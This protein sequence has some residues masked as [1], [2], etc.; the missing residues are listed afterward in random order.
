EAQALKDQIEKRLGA[1]ASKLAQTLNAARQAIAEQRFGPPAPDDAYGALGNALS[2]D[3]YNADDKQL[4]AALPKRILDAATTR[5]QNDAGA[6]AA[7]IEAARKVFP[8]DAAI[9][10]LSTKLQ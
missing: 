1:Q 7:M 9:A 5:A 6:A 10:A 4:L 3:P 8:Q 2:L